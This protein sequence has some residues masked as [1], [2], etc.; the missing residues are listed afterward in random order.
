MKRIFVI[1]AVLLFAAVAFA[2]QSPAV[3]QPHTGT[4]MVEVKPKVAAIDDSVKLALATE[5]NVQLKAQIISTQV[6]EQLDKQLNELRTQF[7]DADKV[8]AAYELKVKK[9]NGWGDDVVFNRQ[10]HKFEKPAPA[11][12]AGK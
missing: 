9:E 10:T 3:N 8:V 12:A 1:T 2:Q 7:V 6:K 5:E 4:P 11:P